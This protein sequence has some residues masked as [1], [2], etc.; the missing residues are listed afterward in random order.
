M[1]LAGNKLTLGELG[2]L[3][4]IDPQVRYRNEWVSSYG[5]VEK[6]S[7]L[8]RQ[9]KKL[10]PEELPIPW[11]Q[12]VERLDLIHYRE[13]ETLVWEA[14]FYAMKLLESAK[15]SKDK[16][17]DISFTLARTT[18]SHGHCFDKDACAEMGLNID[19]T[20]EAIE[21]LSKM[22]ALI[23]IANKKESEAA[24]H[25]IDVVLPE[26]GAVTT[27]EPFPEH[28]ETAVALP[29]ARSNRRN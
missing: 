8:E 18:F 23:H 17:R 6:V 26:I 5:I 1:T 19:E 14:Q 15:Y 20:P 11:K 29:R 12:M 3:T 7:D 9:F 4:P 22:K 16:I 24:T 21:H 27:D 13:M 10:A 2:F 28:Q 25:F